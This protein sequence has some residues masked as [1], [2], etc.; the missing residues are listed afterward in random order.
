MLIKMQN[1]VVLTFDKTISLG[2]ALAILQVGWGYDCLFWP[3]G[4]ALK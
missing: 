4:G 3:W 2:G 1:E